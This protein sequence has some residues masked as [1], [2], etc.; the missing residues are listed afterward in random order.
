M[1]LSKKCTAENGQHSCVQGDD[2]MHRF[3]A[4]PDLSADSY[5][6]LDPEDTRH[7]VKV[8]RMQCGDQAEIIFGNTRYLSVVEKCSTDHVV[9]SPVKALPSTEP[10]L[11]VTLFQGLPKGDKMDWI[12]QKAVEIGAVRI[13][14]VSFSRCVVHLN[15]NDAVKKT[16]R[17][18]KIAREAGKQSGRCIVPEVL[19]PVSPE[20]FSALLSSCG[21]V[22]VPWEECREN[23][24]LSF[25][26]KHPVLSSLG[27]VIGP[28]GG[29]SPEEIG[30]MTDAG[31]EPVTLGK[32]ILRTETAGLTALSVFL[33]LY[34]EME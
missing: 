19:P 32:R 1:R 29:L 11:S 4:D 7:A 17:W 22:A 18:S 12:V 30:R 6:I 13:V 34:G 9:L 3:Y 28:E 8:L 24:P 27:I 23:G 2:V 31:C 20:K 21:K 5:F 15:E 25:F 16:A 14:P 26:R 33:G 10:S